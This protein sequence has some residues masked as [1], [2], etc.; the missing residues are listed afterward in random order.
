[1]YFELAKHPLRSEHIYFFPL[2]AS[3][4]KSEKFNWKSFNCKID[5]IQLN[6]PSKIFA[7]Q[8]NFLLGMTKCS[9]FKIK[10]I[11]KQ[12]L[13][14]FNLLTIPCA[15]A[16]Q[17]LF[18]MNETFCH[19]QFIWTRIKHAFNDSNSVC[20][21]LE[22]HAF[23]GLWIHLGIFLWRGESTDWKLENFSLYLSDYIHWGF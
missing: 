8:W 4:G 18:K 23:W 6:P 21:T 7:E 20:Y 15:N 12:F 13:S 5:A 10:F 16:L 17:L 14:Y 11:F 3:K 9:F 22:K 2:N 19:F 1:M